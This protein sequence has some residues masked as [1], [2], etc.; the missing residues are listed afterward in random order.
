MSATAAAT[1]S[2]MVAVMAAHTLQ[3][4]CG[5]LPAAVCAQVAE[6][7]GG[8][9]LMVQLLC[10]SD[11]PVRPAAGD[12]HTQALPESALFSC[13]YARATNYLTLVSL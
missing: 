6:T 1:R 7:P 11:E 2:P 12:H 3:E 5:A 8:V 13:L 9:A 10:E 4:L